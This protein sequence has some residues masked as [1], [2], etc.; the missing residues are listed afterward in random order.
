MKV[1]KIMFLSK[2][3]IC[4]FHVNLPGCISVPADFGSNVLSNIWNDK[5]RNTV[6]DSFII[7]KKGQQTTMHKDHKVMIYRHISHIIIHHV[8]YVIIADMYV[9]PIFFLFRCFYKN[10]YRINRI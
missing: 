4:R 1:W 6:H 10:P 2:W 9:I 3:A 7:Q 5:W 8:S